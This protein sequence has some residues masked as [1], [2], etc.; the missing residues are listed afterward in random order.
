MVTNRT[1]DRSLKQV[2]EAIYATLGEAMNWDQVQGKWK[3]FKGSVKQQWGKLTDDDLEVIDG[4]KDKLV[5]KLQERYGITREEATRQVR[6]WSPSGASSSNEEN[7]IEEK[8]RR[9]S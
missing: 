1:N 5:G 2:H 4:Q 6:D 3:Q 7:M 9:A 8:R